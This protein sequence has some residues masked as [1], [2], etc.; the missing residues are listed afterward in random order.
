MENHKHYKAAYNAHRNTSF[1]PDRRAAQRKPTI[2][3]ALKIKLGREPT[4]A[5]LKA[6]C[7]RIIGRVTA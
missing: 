6:D 7:L 5:E 2:Y 1:T 3:E 4:N